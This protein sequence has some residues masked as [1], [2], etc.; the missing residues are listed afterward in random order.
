MPIPH[1]PSLAPV[2]RGARGRTVSVLL[3]AAA[4][5]GPAPAPPTAPPT[6]A[7]PAAATPRDIS[8]LVD[9]VR[10]AHGLPAMAG[11]LVTRSGG[12]VALGA[13]GTRRVGGGAAATVQDV[14]HIGSNLKAITAMLAAVAVAQG[15]V[16]WTTTVGTMF[17]ELGGAVRAE[18]R[19]V[20]LAELLAMAG[21]VPRDPPAGTY[22]GA[23]ARAQRD[24]AA[25]WA[26]TAPPGGARGSYLYSN[27]GYVI[28]GAMIERAMGGTFEE[29]LRTQLAAPVGA[30]QLGFGPTALAGS[31]A[32]PVGHSRGAAGWVPCEA[33]DNPPG[34]SAAGR[35][36]LS[37]GDWARLVHELMKAEA[38]SGAVVPQAEARRLVTGVTPNGGMSYALGWNTT[39]RTWGGRTLVHDGSNTVNHSVAWIGLDTGVGLLAVTNAADLPGGTTAAA[40]DALV[41]RILQLHQTGR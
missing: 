34:L 16:S 12:L 30:T 35:A 40:L 38:G 28:A 25:A 26:L 23:T 27:L 37:L 3:L 7:P 6:P 21:G 32:Q 9:S 4:C 18:Y 24:A 33:C 17:P 10:A 1:A 14:W 36:H 19:P 5:T 22:A 41:G 13:A 31:T 39:T 2:R 11:A 8:A 15:R 20:T 29:L